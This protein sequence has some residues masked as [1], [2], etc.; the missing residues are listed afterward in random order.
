MND[1]G[2]L[3]AYA[4]I[5]V[6]GYDPDAVAQP[7]I[8]IDP[9]FRSKPLKVFWEEE[10]AEAEARRLNEV[11]ATRPIHHLVLRTN[12]QLRPGDPEF[13]GIYRG[14]VYIDQ[15]DP[16]D[17]SQG[18]RRY[19]CHW[20]VEGAKLVLTDGFDRIDEALRWARQRAPS[21]T[22]RVDGEHYA[23]GE[24]EGDDELPRW[25]PPDSKDE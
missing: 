9:R 18:R 24:H 10:D 3:W 25:P 17:L 19:D 2:Y 12:V 23:A 1:L 8:E 22:V 15:V 5:Q 21:I 20:E 13:D 4:V 14:S 11:F 7:E 16:D 6:I